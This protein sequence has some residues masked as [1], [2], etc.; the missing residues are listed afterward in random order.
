MKLKF[1]DLFHVR[2]IQILYSLLHLVLSLSHHLLKS[3]NALG[4]G[5]ILIGK[6]KNFGIKLLQLKELIDITGFF[7]WL[8][9]SLEELFRGQG[10][11]EVTWYKIWGPLDVRAT[12]SGTGR[13]WG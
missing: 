5:G 4:Q 10:T 12:K 1:P 8:L 6:L 11:I 13:L 2:I 7:I 3:F 9:K